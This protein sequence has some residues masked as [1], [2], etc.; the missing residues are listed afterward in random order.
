[1]CCNSTDKVRF[2]ASH[3]SVSRSNTVTVPVSGLP[4]TSI[5]EQELPT[6]LLPVALIKPAVDQSSI[7]LPK[8]GDSKPVDLIDYESFRKDKITYP[9]ENKSLFNNEDTQVRFPDRFGGS[10][11]LRTKNTIREQVLKDYKM[12][13]T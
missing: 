1:M 13:I 10:V 11:L 7:P 2:D 5:S 12:G 4:S 3:G 6:V 8:P 9:P